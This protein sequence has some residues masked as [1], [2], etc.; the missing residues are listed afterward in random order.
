[1]AK[2]AHTR[3]VFE[4]V[5]GTVAAPIERWAFGVN[6]PREALDEDGNQTVDDALAASVKQAY[7]D[8]IASLMKPDTILTQ[9]KVIRVGA[10]GKVE[11]RADGS[12][13]QGVWIGSVVGTLAGGPEMPLQTAL[14]VS[15]KTLRSGATGKGRFFLPFPGYSLQTDKRLSSVNAN[16]V[17]I[18]ATEFLND[19]A[20]VMTYAPQVVSSKGYMSEVV[21]TRVGRAPDTMRSRREDLVE[22]YIDLPLA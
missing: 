6:F 14:C 9:V 3:V 16:A 13:A 18:V 17:S 8:N 15:L 7:A 12:Y 5:T 19:L 10:D 1:M 4:G 21:A 2:P 22:G 11:H 20:V